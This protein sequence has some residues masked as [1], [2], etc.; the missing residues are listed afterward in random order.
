MELSPSSSHE[1]RVQLN[2]GNRALDEVVVTALGVKR[3]QKA[4]GYAV[5]KVG[6]AALSSA[7]G[8]DV[9]TSLTGRVA[10][11]NIKNSTEF[12]TTPTIELRGRTPLIVIDGVASQFVSLRMFR[13]MI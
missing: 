6:G 12:N 1:L 4:L 2:T 13:Q 3:E 10:G 9:A 8:V 7:K 5:Q 11:L